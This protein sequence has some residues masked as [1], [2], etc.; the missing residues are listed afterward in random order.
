MREISDKMNILLIPATDWLRH[1]VPSRLHHIFEI[2]AETENVH[3]LQFDLYPENREME[4]NVILHRPFVMPSKDMSM[5]YLLNFP[6]YSAELIKIIKSESIDVVV[7]SNLLPGVPALLGKLSKVKIVY[8]YKDLFQY[9]PFAYYK[10]VFLSSMIKGFLEW[11]LIRLLKNSDLVVTVSLPLVQYLRRLGIQN[12]SFISNGVDLDLFRK[13]TGPPEVL[14]CDFVKDLEGEKNVIGF[15]GTIENWFD[16]ETVLRSLKQV[17]LVVDDVKLLIV[18]GKI[19]TDYFESIKALAKTLGLQD[20]VFFTGTVPHEDVPYYIKMMDVC[21]NPMV[22][23]FQYVMLPDKLFEYLA[24]GK[25]VVSTGAPEILRVGRDAVK[26]YD[27]ESSLS[28]I[29][30]TLLQDENLQSSMQKTAFEIAKN[31]GWRSIAAKYRMLLKELLNKEVK[32]N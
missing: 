8:D 1:P 3:V 21:L 25:P 17:A 13:N 11:L 19:R 5:Y 9:I 28:K 30:T 16:L 15:V 18:G 22:S 14:N 10:S 29:L 20:R 4:T 26:I 6:F 12:V 2:M 31:Y 32:K 27:D 7:I 24:C 23:D